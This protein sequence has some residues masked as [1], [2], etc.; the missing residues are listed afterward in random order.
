MTKPEFIVTSQSLISPA[1]LNLIA[2]RLG[3][4]CGQPRFKYERNIPIGDNTFYVIT[5]TCS[6][7]LPA[8]HVAACRALLLG[9]ELGLTL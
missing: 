6:R 7:Q 5:F 8:K 9:V 4:L 1:K 3:T 2:F